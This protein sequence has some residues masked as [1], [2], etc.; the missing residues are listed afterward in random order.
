VYGVGYD[1]ALLLA[2]LGVGLDGDLLTGKLS[3]GCDAFS[4]TSAIGSG[5]ELGLEGHGKFEG[6]GSLTRNDYFLANGDN[7]SFN[8]TLYQEFGNVTGGLYNLQNI[9]NYRAQR[10]NESLN[11]N[12]NF[13]FGVKSLLLY[14]A[15][16]FL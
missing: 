14:G 1:L 7:F 8:M 3:L 15:A 10:Y 16:S 12:G 2:V 4:R 13:Y 11:T 9:G 5:T 6:D